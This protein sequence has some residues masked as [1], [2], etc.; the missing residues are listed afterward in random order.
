MSDQ[1]SLSSPLPGSGAEV[2]PSSSL[3]STG[4]CEEHKEYLS[5]FCLDDLEPLC[6]QCA[7]D[8]HAY[9]RVYLLAEAAIDCK[10]ELKTSLSGLNMKLK[11][12]EDV[13]QM[14]KKESKRIQTESKLREE[15]LKEEITKLHQFLREEKASRLRTLMEEME[16]KTRKAEERMNRL[17]EVI[18]PLE[19]KIQLTERELHE[20]GDGFEYLQGYNNAMSSTWC[21]DMKPER[22]HRPLINVAKHLGNLR[23]AVW[24]KM[25]QIAPYAPVI[26]DSRTAGEVVRV[27]SEL[28]SFHIT[29]GPSQRADQHINEAIPANPEHFHPQTCILARDGFNTGVHCWDIE[30][31]DTSSWT[32]GVADKD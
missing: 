29:S 27:S 15:T 14:C 22:I 9:H 2:G 21:G 6:K 12:F 25:K 32:V 19:E 28:N 8:S 5:L 16:E 26:L 11:N 20:E 17:S 1:A 31:G 4:C 18:T 10:E 3:E 30:V 7:A 13:L 24:E 23:Y